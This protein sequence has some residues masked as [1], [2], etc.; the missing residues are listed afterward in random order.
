MCS[1]FDVLLPF[2]NNIKSLFRICAL[3]ATI[4][5]NFGLTHRFLWSTSLVMSRTGPLGSPKAL[6]PVSWHYIQTHCSPDGYTFC[7]PF[8]FDFRRSLYQYHLKQYKKIDPG[9]IYS[10]PDRISGKP[11]RPKNTWS[12]IFL[13]KGT[14]CIVGNLFGIMKETFNNW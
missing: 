5:S 7:Q 8:H 4:G 1:R 2:L 3:S 11:A 13:F 9:S 14:F 6:C 10:S 12:F